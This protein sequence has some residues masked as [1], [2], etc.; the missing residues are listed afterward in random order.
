MSM[1][2]YSSLVSDIDNATSNKSEDEL[3]A[4]LVIN[5]SRLDE[6]NDVY[7]AD[8]VSKILDLIDN[9]TNSI[10]NGS[11]PLTRISYQE[12]GVLLDN[13][14][15]PGQ[16]VIMAQKLAEAFN[17]PITVGDSVINVRTNIGVAHFPHH[18]RS[19]SDLIRFAGMAAK[20]AAFEDIAC[21][22]YTEDDLL[23]NS[24]IAIEHALEESLENADIRAYYQPIVDSHSKQA[25]SFEA[26]AR[27][28]DKQRGFVSPNQFIEI[29]EKSH[30]IRD[31]TIFML[32]TV[33]REFSHLH[34]LYP[35]AKVSVNISPTLLN[36]SDITS[37]LKRALN[38]WDM[39][40]EYLIIE[41]TES[42]IMHDFNESS[43]I[44]RK[45]REMGVEV[46]VDDFGMGQASLKYI[47]HLVVS[48]IKIDKT[49][50]LNLP[51][52]HDDRKIVQGI[53]D[54]AHN[55]GIHV[56]AEG[57]E[58]DESQQILEELECDFL[59]GFHFAK[60]MPLEH[61]HTWKSTG[62]QTV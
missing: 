32:N 7:S 56:V 16:A 61:L 42:A 52:D 35:E 26:L 44:L 62:Q 50:I 19:A 4:V 13:L 11:Y 30:L 18:G 58:S 28:W 31:L 38:I 9:Y 27:W 24:S 5:C 46:V 33:M 37:L 12:Y 57:V 60:P 59:Q 2:D 29:A 34:E 43:H 8:A 49:F 20:K 10:L 3:F 47:K 1:R 40:P 14:S 17:Q 53:I 25:M 54:L 6:I 51:N 15:I 55:L 39:P 22:T 23:G 48:G 41:I 21:K 36:Y 45:F